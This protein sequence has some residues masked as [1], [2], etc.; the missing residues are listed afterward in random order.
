M[1]KIHS[2]EQLVRK[3]RQMDKRFASG[4][5]VPGLSISEA[6][7]HHWRNRY[8]RMNPSETKRLKELEKE[9]TR[10]KRSVVYQTLDIQILMKARRNNF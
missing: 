9:N 8:G 6:T 10:L 5:W 3:L 1:N 4:A 7:Y 2:P